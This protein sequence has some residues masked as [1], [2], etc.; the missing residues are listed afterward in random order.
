[1][2]AAQYPLGLSGV[3]VELWNKIP[4]PSW[5]AVIAQLLFLG[6]GT[7]PWTEHGFGAHNFG[8][9]PFPH[10][11][12]KTHKGQREELPAFRTGIHSAG[13]SEMPGSSFSSGYI[14]HIYFI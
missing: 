3:G 11:A 6:G 10:R 14:C 12:D 5:A 1:M 9:V 8:D 7:L 2:V 4:F 13:I